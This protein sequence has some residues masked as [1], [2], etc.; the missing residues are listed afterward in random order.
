MKLKNGKLIGL[1]VDR[2]GGTDVRGLST[3]GTA[4]R[5]FFKKRGMDTEYRIHFR[6]KSKKAK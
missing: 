1:D 3:V 6:R 4:C 2:H 5:E